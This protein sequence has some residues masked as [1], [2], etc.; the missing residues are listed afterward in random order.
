MI[1]SLLP[2]NFYLFFCHL[3]IFSKSTFRKNSFRNTIWVSNRLDPGQARNLFRPDL[4]PICLQRLWADD[5][6]WQWVDKGADQSMKLG[7][8]K[9]AFDVSILLH[10][11]YGYL[12][13]YPGLE[14]LILPMLSYP[15]C[16]VRATYIGCIGTNAHCRQVTSL[17]CSNDIIMW[18]CILAH[19]GTSGSLFLNKKKTVV[20]KKK[21][22]LF[23]W[24]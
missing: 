12:R 14:N 23:K 2:G 11:G 21:N 22:P 7:R 10:T 5:T 13:F 8:F 6:S 4:G 19:I 17:L 9:C 15:V 20:S 16:H 1:N 3:L 24:G 18:N